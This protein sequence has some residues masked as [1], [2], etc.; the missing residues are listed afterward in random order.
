MKY[1]P[2]C[3]AQLGI[4]VHFCACGYEITEEERIRRKKEESYID[5]KKS[6]RI[7]GKGIIFA[8]TWER[9][10][11]FIIDMMFITIIGYIIA[12]PFPILRRQTVLDLFIPNFIDLINWIVGFSYYWLFETYNKGQTIGKKILGLRTVDANSFETTSKE[13]YAI[14]NLLRGS[15][16]LFL[17]D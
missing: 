17:I 13:K 3:G 1:C 2:K 7:P 10:I 9:L 4:G 11:A 5:L 16:L 14:N 8:R 12:L 6:A 15:N